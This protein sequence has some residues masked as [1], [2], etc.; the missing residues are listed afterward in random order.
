MGSGMGNHVGDVQASSGLWT[1][2]PPQEHTDWRCPGG[3]VGDADQYT[4]RYNPRV[5]H[6][7][8]SAHCASIADKCH[9]ACVSPPHPRDVWC[10]RDQSAIAC[11]ARDNRRDHPWC[12]LG[13]LAALNGLKECSMSPMK[14]YAK[15]HAKARQRRRLQAHE[16]LERERRQAQHA[17]EA[18]HQS[19]A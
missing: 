10:M 17:A 19:P 16:R 7:H 11:S 1:R 18:L 6:V 4:P 13:C 14:R 2:L 12:R 15:K 5:S 9:M 8:A 3:S